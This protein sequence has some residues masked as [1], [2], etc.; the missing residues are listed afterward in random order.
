MRLL[1]GVFSHFG[2]LMG[3]P[4]VMM[5]GMASQDVGEIG[6]SSRLGLILNA[7]QVATGNTPVKGV[8]LV[9]LRLLWE[10]LG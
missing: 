7:F 3:S 2:I 4:R 10:L 1:G 8:F 6:V 9:I 5:G